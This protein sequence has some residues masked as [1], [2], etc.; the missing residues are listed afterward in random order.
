MSRLNVWQEIPVNTSNR[1]IFVQGE[2]ELF[3]S[4]HVGLYQGKLKFLALQ[5]GRVYLTSKRLIF[6]A[7][8]GLCAVAVDLR[9]FYRAE[10]V[11]KFLRSLPKVKLYLL[12]DEGP[13]A[14]SAPLISDW[15]CAVCSFN[16]HYDQKSEHPPKCVAC[17]I[18][19]SAAQVSALQ[20]TSARVEETALEPASE[21]ATKD[22][23]HV[24]APAPHTA[25][26]CPKCTF[27]NHPSMRS[28]EICGAALKAGSGLAKRKPARRVQDVPLCLQLQEAEEYTNNEPYIK[29]SFRK[30]GHRQFFEAATLAIE[31]LKWKEL[32]GKGAVNKHATRVV[33]PQPTLPGKVVHGGISA[34][35]KSEEM[36]RLNNERVLSLSLNDL[37][38]LMYK[39]RDVLQLTLSFSSLV[40]KKSRFSGSASGTVSE[41]QSPMELARNLSEFLINYELTRPTSMATVQDVF[42]SYNR[43]RLAMQGF[44][45][46]VVGTNQMHSCMQYFDKL[47]LPVKTKTFLSGLRVLTQRNNNSENEIHRIILEYI[48]S[49]ENA[50][51]LQ[52]F[53]SELVADSD[54]YMRSQL[55]YFPGKSV[56]D[57]SVHFGWATTICLEEI[58]RCLEKALLVKDNH[59]LGTFYHANKFDPD[60]LLRLSDHQA[61][62]TLA[63][64]N[65]VEQQNVISSDLKNQ[66]TAPHSLVTLQ[67]FGLGNEQKD[68]EPSSNFSES[69]IQLDGLKFE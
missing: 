45:G 69:L 38:Q 47:Q 22:A 4:D 15:V 49:E 48:I 11:D 17:G 53:Q 54:G 61:L 52:K 23:P 67:E 28:C 5:N 31:S 13:D 21:P 14:D 32:Q 7:S 30:G 34:I 1:P 24:A 20:N 16:N 66:H 68:V 46:Q 19:A 58:E 60:I 37:E 10:F 40:R 56:V 62:R 39:A 29:V 6:L 41:V 43:Y 26:Q 57:I 35:E 27:L 2:T 9:L 65:M 36:Q 59:I 63:R 18:L 42:A 51:M 55:R 44:G 12:S 50:F 3:S 25:G 8:L 64:E 33:E